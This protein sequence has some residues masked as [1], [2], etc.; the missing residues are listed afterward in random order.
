MVF[1]PLALS[2]LPEA[3]LILVAFTDEPRLRTLEAPFTVI[4]PRSCFAAVLS[5]QVF[6]TLP[7]KVVVAVP[8]W[9]VP[10][11][12]MVR[13][14]WRVI[15]CAPGEVVPKFIATVPVA[16]KGVENAH[17]AAVAASPKVT[18]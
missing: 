11:A 14:P 15:A 16:V 3:M 12:P 7:E 8:F 13:S 9:K 5:V 18:L 10:L 6:A 1:A 4:L 2:V 17:V